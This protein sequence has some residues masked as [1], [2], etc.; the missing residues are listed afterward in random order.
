MRILSGLTI[1]FIV[2]LLVTELNI[3]YTWVKKINN[4]YIKN[5]IS[6]KLISKES[7]KIIIFYFLIVGLQIIIQISILLLISEII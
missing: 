3:K 4:K 7:N 1:A 2:L 5:F 6:K